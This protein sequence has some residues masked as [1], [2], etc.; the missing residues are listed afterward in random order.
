[1]LAFFYSSKKYH[2]QAVFKIDLRQIRRSVIESMLSIRRRSGGDSASST[3]VALFPAS[4]LRHRRSRRA[5]GS[6]R[7]AKPVAS[8]KAVDD[9]AAAAPDR[10]ACR[11]SQA[12]KCKGA[13]ELRAS[14]SG[15]APHRTFGYSVGCLRCIRLT[16]MPVLH[17]RLQSRQADVCGATGGRGPGRRTLLQGRTL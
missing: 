3:F 10:S 16:S 1:M 4:P 17:C 11:G 6:G 15:N 5:G 13:L 8:P 12:G 9:G 7:S 2:F 14:R